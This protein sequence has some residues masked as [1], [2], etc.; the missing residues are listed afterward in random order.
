MTATWGDLFARAAPYDVSEG[1]VRR[2]LAERRGE[3]FDG[4]D[5]YGGDDSERGSGE[6]NAESGARS[7]G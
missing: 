7:D 1:D 4:D 3:G 6:E 2:A 5:E